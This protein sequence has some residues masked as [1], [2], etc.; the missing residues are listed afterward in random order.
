MIECYAVLEAVGPARILGDVPTDCARRFAG[1]IG[2]VKQ[3]ER[4]N[5]FVEAEV[6]DARLDGGAAILDVERND[7][8][9]PMKSYHYDVVGERATGQTGSRTARNEGQPLFGEESHNRDR[10]IAIAGE[11]SETWLPSVAGQAVGVVNQQLALAA[12]YMTLAHDIG[13]MLRHRRR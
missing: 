2:S 7:R 1:R 4:R 3:A 12:Q 5:V 13:E 6:N 8:L 11:D 9:E 10:L